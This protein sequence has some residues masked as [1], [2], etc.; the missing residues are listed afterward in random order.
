MKTLYL[1]AWSALWRQKGF[2]LRSRGPFS[3]RAAHVKWSKSAKSLLFRNCSKASGV[4]LCELHRHFMERQEFT[5]VSQCYT[6]FQLKHW[7]LLWQWLVIMS[8][9]FWPSR[10]KSLILLLLFKNWKVILPLYWVVSTLTTF[11]RNLSSYSIVI[12][13]LPKSNITFLYY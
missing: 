12:A 7:H 2:P 10:T 3:T 9:F 4:P 11:L 13:Q 1:R 6:S 5:V 8:V